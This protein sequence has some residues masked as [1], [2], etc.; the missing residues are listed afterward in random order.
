[1]SDEKTKTVKSGY[2]TTEFWFSSIA[3]LL[4]ILLASGA[5]AE[6]GSVEKIMGMAATVCAGLG[7][8]VSRGL[9]KRA[10]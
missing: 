3:A 6:G 4:G 7:Y 1:M 5:V 10:S 2:K 9:S 8:S